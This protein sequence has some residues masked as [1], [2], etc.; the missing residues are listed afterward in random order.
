MVGYIMGVGRLG[1]DRSV[2]LPRWGRST[3]KR[4]VV[5]PTAAADEA[6]AAGTARGLPILVWATAAG[7][8][9]V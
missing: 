9:A 5:V 8:W 1:P 6:S 4:V 2:S 7:G 3:L